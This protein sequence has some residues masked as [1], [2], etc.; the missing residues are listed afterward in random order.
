MTSATI[1]LIDKLKQRWNKSSSLSHCK[2]VG[3]TILLTVGLNITCSRS[4]ELPFPFDNCLFPLISYVDNMMYLPVIHQCKALQILKLMKLQFVCKQVRYCFINDSPYVS[5]GVLT[6]LFTAATV[7]FY[8]LSDLC[9]LVTTKALFVAST[10]CKCS[11]KCGHSVVLCEI[12][13][14]T[15][16][17]YFNQCWILIW[18]Q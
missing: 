9:M 1:S 18:Y 7:L 4:P 15:S 16:I 17:W 13:I 6:N 2:K 8:E 5:Y 3:L 11:D 14:V 10:L 12:R